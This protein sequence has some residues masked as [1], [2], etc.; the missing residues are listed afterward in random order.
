MGINVNNELLSKANEFIYAYNN[1][2]FIESLL[3]DILLM[4]VQEGEYKDS[5]G[6]SV[7]RY[8]TKLTLSDIKSYF[9]SRSSK[10]RD[11]I[12]K[13][14]NKYRTSYF[15]C[16]DKNIQ[17]ITDAFYDDG[18]LIILF[19]DDYYM[20][21]INP[22]NNFTSFNMYILSNL[23]TLYALR[24]YELIKSYMFSYHKKDD[25]YVMEWSYAKMQFLLNAI[26]IDNKTVEILSQI[27]ASRKNANMLYDMA[28]NQ[29]KKKY[30]TP[31][32]FTKQ[33]KSAIEEINEVTD[34]NIF[35]F[36][37]KT[38]GTSHKTQGYTF[39]AR[40]KGL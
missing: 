13:A 6:L 36:T 15:I 34:I 14:C 21:Y 40:K 23:K 3:F 19:S 35:D 10:I 7:R 9:P 30:A 31:G 1:Y 26:T 25:Y 39:S 11:S 16:Q 22:A 29:C 37:I 5:N 38:V 18:M 2:N 12:I 4:H 27:D 28:F 24:L 8:M 17:L 33:I 32:L 20:Y